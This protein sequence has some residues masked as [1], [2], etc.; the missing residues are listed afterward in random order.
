M[1]VSLLVQANLTPGPDEALASLLNFDSLCN[2]HFD[3]VERRDIGG[4]ITNHASLV[5]FYLLYMYSASSFE[6]PI[7]YFSHKIIS[8][9]S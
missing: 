4:A 3:H 5:S 2:Q 8:S 9:M 6:M 1:H 7:M